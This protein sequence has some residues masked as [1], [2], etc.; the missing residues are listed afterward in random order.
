MVSNHDSFVNP[1]Y[2]GVVI[3]ARINAVIFPRAW[4]VLKHVQLVKILN[5]V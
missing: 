5:D 1:F 4:R 3:K 2:P